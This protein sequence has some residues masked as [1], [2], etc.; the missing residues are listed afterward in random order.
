[1]LV[2]EFTQIYQQKLSG[3]K[4]QLPSAPSY[5]QYVEWMLSQ[6]KE[7]A[8]AFWDQFL[9]GYEQPVAVPKSNHAT[10]TQGYRL[11]EH[12]I[13]LDTFTSRQLRQLARE[14]HVTVNV[15]MQTVWACILGKINNVNDVVFG[16][17]VSGRP[18][19]LIDVEKTVGL[20]LQSIPLRVQWQASTNFHDLMQQVQQVFTECES[21]HICSM[22]EI[23]SLTPL[24][25]NL[26]D[27]MFVFENYP[28]AEADWSD[29]LGFRM[30][31]VRGYEQMNYDFGLVIHPGE[32]IEI[33][34]TYNAHAH[35]TKQIQD[36]AQTYQS[37]VRQA[38]SHKQTPIHELRMEGLPPK[39]TSQ[40]DVEPLAWWKRD[41]TVLDF[42]ENQV[43]KT[44]DSIAV[45][46]ATGAITYAQLDREANA[47]A[48]ALK[49]A[50]VGRDGLVGIFMSNCSKYVVSTLAV[51]K[52]GGV[53]VPLDPIT[54]KRRLESIVQKL[55]C[56]IWVT[57]S[58]HLPFLQNA[59]HE[60]QSISK[61]EHM[62]WADETNTW[63]HGSMGNGKTES[64]IPSNTAKLEDRPLPADSMYIMF[65]SGSTGEPKAILGGHD[66]LSHFLQWQSHELG[67]DATLR[68]SNLAPVMFDVSLRDIY[69]PLIN[70]GRV[71]IPTQE[72]RSNLAQLLQWL[73]EKQISLIHIVPSMYR[74]LLN[75]LESISSPLDSFR[76]LRMVL[77]AGEPVFEKDIQRGHSLLGGHVEFINLYGPSETI[78]AKLFHRV[79]QSAQQSNRVVLLGKPIEGAQTFLIKNKRE[80]KVGE[81]GEIYIQ[82][83]F[84][85]KGYYRDPEKTKEAFVPSPLTQ[86]STVRVYKTGDLG[87]LTEGG[88]VEFVGRIDRQVKINGVRVELAEVDR[89]LGMET[90]I[91]QS[92]VMVHRKN[93]GENVLVAYYTEKTPLNE[94]TLRAEMQ[95][96][97][98]PAM[99]PGF[100]VRMDKFPYNINGKIDRRALPKPDNLIYER[101]KFEPPQNE[102]E[103]KLVEIWKQVLGIEKVSVNSPFLHIGGNSLKAIR[104]ISWINRELNTDLRIRTFFELATI[105]N[106]AQEIGSGEQKNLENIEPLPKRHD[107]PLSHAQRRLWI[108]QQLEIDAKAYNLPTAL[109]MDGPFNI[110]AFCEAMR[111]VVDR[112]ESLRTTFHNINNEPRQV[113]H[114]HVSFAVQHDDLRQASDPLRTAKKKAREEAGKPFDLSACPL[115]RV[116]LYHIAEQRYVLFANIHHIVFDGTSAGVLIRDILQLYQSLI[117]KEEPSLTPLR[118]QYKDFAAWQNTRLLNDSMQA[119]RN[120]WKAKLAPPL[121]LLNL[122]TDFPRPSMQTFAGKT[123]YF[124]L[125]ASL[126]SWFR[127]LCHAR[128]GSMYMGVVA[129]IKMLLY[130]YTGQTESII[131]SV[132]AGR[133]HEELDDQVG[134]YVNT[135][136]L[137]DALEPQHGFDKNFETI[138][139]TIT[140]AF[141]HREYPFDKIV[142]DLG[143]DRDMSRPPLAEIMVVYQNMD[144][145]DF[146]MQGVQISELDID[147]QSSKFPLSFVFEEQNGGTVSLQIEYNTDLFHQK[148]MENMVAHLQELLRGLQ[149]QPNQP[150]HSINLLPTVERET[151]LHACN[152]TEK[153][154][155]QQQTLISIIEDVVDNTPEA[156]AVIS[157]SQEWSYRELN[158]KANQLAHQLRND[159]NIQPG[160]HV[161]VF[162]SRSPWLPVAFLGIQ[163]AGAVYVPIDPTYPRERVSF[164]LRDCKASVILTDSDLDPEWQQMAEHCLDIRKREEREAGN[165]QIPIKS[166]DVA[167]VIYTSGSTGQP[168]GVLVENRGAVNL[169]QFH[170]DGLNIK[171]EDRVLQFAPASF[172]ASVWEMIMALAQGACLV[173]AGAASIYDRRRFTQY[174]QEKS[175]TVATLPPSYVADF[176]R[177]A[178][179]SLRLLIT[180]GEA[181]E[182]ETALAIGQ[183]VEYVNAYGP[184]ESTICASAHRVDPQAKYPATIPIGQ[185]IQNMEILVLD[186]NKNLM[187]MGHPGEMYIG[188]VGIARGYLNRES[189][190]NEKFVPHP[191]RPGETLYRS[192]DRGLWNWDGEIEFLG[193]V[194]HQV[195]I[196]GHRIELGE[197]EHRLKQ[198]PQVDAA[199]VNVW[200]E[201]G[202]NYLAAYL[203]SQN[204][205]NVAT[206]RDHAQAHLPDFMIPHYWVNMDAIPLLPNGKVDR[207]QLPAPKE[208]AMDSTQAY[209]APETKQQHCL[210]NIWARVLGRDRVGIHDRF[211]ELGGDSIKAIQ[212]VA[213]LQE[214]GYSLTVKEL[215]R[216]PTIELLAP[217]LTQHSQ[218]ALTEITSEPI[219]FT[220]IQHWFFH[221]HHH[222]L[223]HFNQSVLL[224][225]AQSLQET[226]LRKALLY[227]VNY[228]DSLR[229]VFPSNEEK[230]TQHYREKDREFDLQV[231]DVSHTPHF[232]QAIN[233]QAQKVQESMQ[234][235]QGPLFKAALIRHAEKERLLLVAHHLIVDGVTWRIVIEDL[236]TAYQ[237]LSEGREIQLPAKDASYQQWAE[238]LQQYSQSSTIRMEIPFWREMD[239]WA[240]ITIPADNHVAENRYGDSETLKFVLSMRETK[241]L[242]QHAHHAYNT[243]MN[244]LLLTALAQSLREWMQT[245]TCLIALEGHGREPI[246]EKVRVYRTAGWFTSLF[247]FA[248]P[249]QSVDIGTHIKEVK[250]ALRRIPQKGV[251]YGILKTLT[252]PALKQDWQG[253]AQP[254]IAFNYLGQ[255]DRESGQNRFTPA[256]EPMGQTE[257]PHLERAHALEWDGYVLNNQLQFTLRYHR[258]MHRAETIA[259]LLNNFEQ[260]LN[261]IIA[262]CMNQ[263]SPQL[264]PSD[265]T[266][267]DMNLDD[268]ENLFQDE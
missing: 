77:L 19:Q 132:I 117:K 158:A 83:P 37:V 96:Y 154:F 188:G 20:F 70:G 111:M 250:E 181:A 219:P 4:A 195:K 256:L 239:Q 133:D 179:S 186:D 79:N 244:D 26:V 229:L 207:K 18:P 13:Y 110:N 73:L 222:D 172:D 208:M 5:S 217:Q 10:P 173:V 211:F 25:H 255:F 42:F 202:T 230:R 157:E 62:F 82:T 262:H 44:P 268:F 53:F 240:N 52:A 146:A 267:V 228:H 225:S 257:S 134:F 65:T 60:S 169:S 197:I 43:A 67:V 161:G 180:A 99:I 214:E 139:Q 105:R 163:K 258:E 190:T 246:D 102:I 187:P 14:N 142:D 39:P 94:D 72:Q 196:R 162:I 23:L 54:P 248:L 192:G 144:Q 106:I 24:K 209:T 237:Q 126:L 81:I 176:P 9:R 251:G 263:K 223:H 51:Q 92:V 113:V 254:Q 48:H 171:P 50:Q 193:R 28:M 160:L 2:D 59:L 114:D 57:N 17:V 231:V 104:A 220:P 148:R 147:F 119:H 6:E 78:L 235:E 261:T 203:V 204:N 103:Q 56:T 76:H 38:V 45:E 233:E 128:G 266:R 247:P 159:Y 32:E 63:R 198:H 265:V 97:L 40:R 238:M 101:E 260:A 174:L 264:T 205:L 234:L 165:P 11:Q 75:E 183:C 27:H 47:L 88:E 100:F 141:E 31:D 112:H 210:C 122:Q 124:E 184:T 152:K 46:D 69:L 151:I 55:E 168:K 29:T 131:G 130:R 85:C 36:V 90:A 178:F 137:R 245:D 3:K 95:Q 199:V 91:D 108:L 35:T 58:E 212:I 123:L 200:Q 227:L 115:I 30:E 120:Y 98:P 8:L 135:L 143:L 155:P 249:L 34:F 71:V 109:L 140:E 236:T 80:A 129:L 206:L 252:P 232:E 175:V 170:R 84:P 224:Q 87:R 253:L 89:V 213:L 16:I 177:E 216:T 149:S 242:Q 156:K 93:D 221:E 185:P 191:W 218:A 118:I 15:V 136:V 66:G 201:D 150:I 127:E 164:M 194:D 1:V 7:K 138:K 125:D 49:S 33:K 259:S 116:I 241:D 41:S 12:V 215:F 21:R 167:Y 226:L 64:I 22:A 189:L 243:E 61:T 86:D 153:D 68:A 145:R 182:A 166:S 74:L 121:P 107:Y